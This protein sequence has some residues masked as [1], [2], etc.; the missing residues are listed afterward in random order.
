MSYD[1]DARFS[2]DV[3]DPADALARLMG[4]RSDPADM[5]PEEQVE[6]DTEA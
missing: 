4:I 5:E 2:L 1:P 3:D 6:D